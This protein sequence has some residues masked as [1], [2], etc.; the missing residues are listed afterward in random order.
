MYTR[1]LHILYY[2]QRLYR[3][4]DIHES[5]WAIP[6]KIMTDEYKESSVKS[7]QPKF[8]P[9]EIPIHLSGSARADQGI[10]IS[11]VS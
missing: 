6:Q 3:V 7:V 2:F 9:K 10:E 1:K 4:F 5:K 8:T 11:S